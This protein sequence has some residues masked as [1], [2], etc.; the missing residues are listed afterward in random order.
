MNRIMSTL[1]L[2]GIVL[3]AALPAAAQPASF[4]FDKSHT[5]I[6]FRIDHFGFST[7]H[8][9]F[10]EF[11]GKLVLDEAKPENSKVTFTI[12]ADSV[13]TQFA[14]RD[15]HIRSADFLDAGRF[16]TMS[17]VSTLVEPTGEGRAKVHGTLTLRGVAKPVV[18]DVRLNQLAVSP[19]DQRLTAGFTA[20]TVIKRTEWGI[21]TYAPAIGDE[22][23]IRI[24]AEAARAS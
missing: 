20:E 18:L 23:H 1:A 7:T 14:A 4:A 15:T 12:R 6:Y 24:D 16:P 11:D 19:V 5:Q 8:G 13:D 9:L 2:A 22:V 10:R 3:L 17:F 21:T